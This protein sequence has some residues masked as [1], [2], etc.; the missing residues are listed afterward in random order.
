MAES[1]KRIDGGLFIAL[2]GGE[3]A[4]KSSVGAR[5]ASQ[6]EADGYEVV[7]TREPGGTRLGEALRAILLDAGPAGGK[8]SGS[9][10]LLLFSAARHA[11]VRTVI[12]PAL[13]RG[14]IVIS[15][16]YVLSTR[17]YQ[18]I[19]GVPEAD[20]SAISAIATEGLEPHRTYWFDLPP[21]VGLSRVA[22]QSRTERSA[23]DDAKLSYHEELRAGFARQAEQNSSILR[24]DATKP[25]P[26]VESSVIADIRLQLNLRAQ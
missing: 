26:E 25:M 16:R 14:A 15:D 10:I 18:G 3:G 17:V 1:I 21:E 24:I 12:K 11:H 7:F 4:G 5:V 22:Q 6:L 2:E 20:I 9:E 8:L 23:Y 19:D 13:K